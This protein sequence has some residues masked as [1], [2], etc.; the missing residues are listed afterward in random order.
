MPPET[1][2]ETPD[3]TQPAQTH[4]IEITSSGFE[5]RELT[6]NEGDT[7]T[8]VNNDGPGRWPAS[9]QHPTHTQYP[10]VEYNEGG[11]FMGSRGCM[12]EGESKEGAFDACQELEPGEEWSFTFTETGTWRYHDHRDSTKGGT[13]EVQ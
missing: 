6:I 4:T 9:N 13:I 3:N 10:G 8:W 12:G 2:P 1:Q 11:S 5:P 7:V